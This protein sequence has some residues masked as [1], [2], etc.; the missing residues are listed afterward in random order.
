MSL[1][2]FWE[3]GMDREAWHAAVHGIAESDTNEQLN[4]NSPRLETTQ[5]DFNMRMVSKLWYIHKMEFY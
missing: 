2:K 4:C 5:I 1:S 3:L